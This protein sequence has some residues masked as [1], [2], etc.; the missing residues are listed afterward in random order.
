[1][2]KLFAYIG[3]VFIVGFSSYFGYGYVQANKYADTAIPYMEKVLPQLSTW[4]AAIARQFMAPEVAQTVTEENLQKLM[5]ALS[6]LG[7]LNSITEFSFK[8]S[9]GID[10]GLLSG[11]T[12]ITYDV[13]S[14]YST[15][16]AVVTLRL[17]ERSGAYELYHFNF[18][19][20]ALG[21]R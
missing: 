9:V 16:A 13:E 20:A 12:V 21:P 15:G 1:M 14:E 17:L 6:K 5:L 19:S 2:K 4:D 10:D 18:Q 3:F 7:S 11:G 8:N